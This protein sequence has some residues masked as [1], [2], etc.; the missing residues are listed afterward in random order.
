MKFFTF[1]AFVALLA[2]ASANDVKERIKQHRE[3]QK[4]DRENLIKMLSNR[5][6]RRMLKLG[7]LLSARKK[8]IDDHN[9][10]RRR[11]NSEDHA[12]VLRQVTN[13][14]RKLDE[15]NSKDKEEH[16]RFLEHEADAYDRMNSIDYIDFD[17]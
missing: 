11:L 12:R 8:E 7:E 6:D 16:Q 5:H 2:V 3:S 13:F 15:M 17:K 1:A 14:Q 4:L 10:G 9:S